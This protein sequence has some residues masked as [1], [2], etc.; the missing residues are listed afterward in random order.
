MLRNT[1]RDSSI[2]SHNLN[3]LQKI[4]SIEC[5]KL[6][7]TQ[8]FVKHSLN[9]SLRIRDCHRINRENMHLAQRLQSQ[10]SHYAQKPK[11]TNHCRSTISTSLS[12]KKSISYNDTDNRDSRLSRNSRFKSEVD[13]EIVGQNEDGFRNRDILYNESVDINRGMYWLEFSR[14]DAVFFVTMESYS[15]QRKWKLRLSR[16]VGEYMCDLL[17]RQRFAFRGRVC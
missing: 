6:T 15:F 9:I 5:R 2:H 17:E 1:E 10:Q 8:P 3:L 14:T 13:E 11:A 4:E 12:K 7:S 16:N